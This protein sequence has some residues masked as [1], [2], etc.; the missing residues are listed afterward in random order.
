MLIIRML[1]TDYVQAVA[2]DPQNALSRALVKYTESAV[3]ELF[4]H[5]IG[6]PVFAVLG[7]H[8][9]NPVAI[10]GLSPT[11]QFLTNAHVYLL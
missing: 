6:S 3:F 10:D 11:T 5:Y 2:H 9:T 4:K 7:N 8:D 1:F